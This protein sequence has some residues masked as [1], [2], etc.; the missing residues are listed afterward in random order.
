M[1]RF[2][3][4][5]LS[6]LFFTACSAAQPEPI[7]TLQLPISTPFPSTATRTVIPTFTLIPTP[8]KT[9]IPTY[10][11]MPVTTVILGYPGNS[12]SEKERDNLW[13]YLLRALLLD[14]KV[15]DL[16]RK[17][18]PSIV[19]YPFF[20][21]YLPNWQGEEYYEFVPG[22]GKYLEVS[23]V[24]GLATE[25]DICK[26]I[27]HLLNVAYPDNTQLLDNYRI[28]LG[29]PDNEGPN[30]EKDVDLPYCP[31]FDPDL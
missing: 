16:A 21:K 2:Y 29:D 15:I 18:D 9:K 22:S 26:L 27:D 1:R 17:L 30:P 6:V 28:L 13:K 12:W 5:V 8:T 14:Q 19:W 25:N 7:A 4:L 23:H 20:L 3:F 11:S 10:T 24:L 31:N